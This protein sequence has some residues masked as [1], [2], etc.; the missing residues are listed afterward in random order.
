MSKILIV[1]DDKANSVLLSSLL[2]IYGYESEA[3]SSAAETIAYVERE[4]PRAILMDL[5]IPG[6]DGVTLTRQLKTDTR[7]SD[8][9][10]IAVTAKQFLPGEE[11][12]LR[13]AGFA[14]YVPK[15]VDFQ[16]LHDYLIELA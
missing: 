1:E 5:R 15:P 12:E 9:P 2:E 14:G 13:S 3:V 4:C 16:S 8:V 10:V 11:D 6:S 7:L